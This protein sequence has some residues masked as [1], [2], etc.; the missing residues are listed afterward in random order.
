M[1]L[2]N[3]WLRNIIKMS[4]KMTIIRPLCCIVDAEKKLSALFMNMILA[5]NVYME[6]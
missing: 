5:L 6:L 3:G 2:K 1:G 4:L